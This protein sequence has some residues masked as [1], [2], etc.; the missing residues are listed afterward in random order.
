MSQHH[1]SHKTVFVDSATTYDH[2]QPS[3][4]LS[5]LKSMRNRQPIYLTTTQ[6]K[7]SSYTRQLPNLPMLCS[8]S[9]ITQAHPNIDNI[10]LISL[11]KSCDDNCEV[12]LTKNR[13]T[14]TKT[15]L[16]L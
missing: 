1:F 15:T 9:I 5:N 14:F 6:I 12:K 8:D 2:T 13:C 7:K 3:A 4:F 16:Q 10:S 11:R